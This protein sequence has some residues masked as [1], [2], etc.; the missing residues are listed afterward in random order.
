VLVS[1]TGV[2]TI[3]FV[4]TDPQWSGWSTYGQMCF[5]NITL[6]AYLPVMDAVVIGDP[7]SESGHAMAGWGPVEPETSGGSYGGI[8]QCRAI[9]APE[10]NDVWATIEMDFGHCVEGTKCLTMHHL[11]GISV[12]SF[13]L[14]IYAPG[15]S[16]PA[17]PFWSYTGTTETAEIWY[18]TSLAVTQI[19]PQV[20]EF[21]STEPTW[22][23]WDIYG[24]VCFGEIRVQCCEPCGPTPYVYATVGIEPSDV[25][26]PGRLTSIAPNPF[27]PKTDISFV[28]DVDARVELAV[29]D[30]R[31]H[32][33]V[34]LVDEELRADSY[35]FAWHGL[36][37][38]GERAASGV[39]FA[40]LKIGSDYT[41]VGKVSMIK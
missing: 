27:N 41:D 21:V 24:Q 5:N 34:T 36:D 2:Q 22:S 10:D 35:S 1:G 23:M 38:T 31:G 19:G 40:R 4:S 7:A 6:S 8:S 30:M 15:E 16:R 18:R 39:Y 3:K 17:T 28:L 12:D 26:V 13:D 33:V 25:P 20:V 37:A 9:Y 11:D 14:Y 32:R 29:Y